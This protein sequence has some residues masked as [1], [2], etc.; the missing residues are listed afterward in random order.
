MDAK[1]YEV[2]VLIR[3]AKQT[4]KHIRELI[5]ILENK[6]KGHIWKATYH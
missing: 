4:I 5:Q 3:S 1:T 2:A 6:L